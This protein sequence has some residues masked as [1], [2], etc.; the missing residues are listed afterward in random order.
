MRRFII[1][2][3]VGLAIAGGVAY[4]TIPDSGGVIHGCFR[5][6]VGM[7]RVIDPSARQL[8][9]PNA[10]PFHGSQTGPTGPAGV[11][12]PAGGSGYEVDI[13]DATGATFG[14]KAGDAMTAAFT[15]PTGKKLLS[16]GHGGDWGAFVSEAPSTDGTTWT[17]TGTVQAT[18]FTGLTIWA[19][20]AT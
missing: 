1:G 17:V 15:C 5:N 10:T 16:G 12:G 19:I 11:T 20:C 13:V 2:V 3:A 4:A 8:C 7:L 14:K 18:S 6:E 9:G